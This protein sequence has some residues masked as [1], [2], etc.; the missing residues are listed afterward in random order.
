MEWMIK[1]PEGYQKIMTE[2]NV[3]PLLAKVLCFGQDDREQQVP[4]HR[5]EC[6]KDYDKVL[7]RIEKAIAGKEKV[8]IYGDYDCDGITATSIMVRAFELRGLAVGFHIPDRFTDGYGL[9]VRR[10]EEMAKKGYSLIITVDNGVSAFEAVKRANELGLDVIITDHHDLPDVLPEAYAIIHTQLSENYPFKGISGG[11]V[12]CKLATAMLKRQDPYI[13]CLAAL[14]TISDMMPMVDEN[15][16][17]VKKALEVMNTQHYLSLDLLLGENQKYDVT[18]LGFVIAPKINSIG[19]LEDGMN[20]NKCVTYFRHSGAGSDKE[21]EFKIQFA[22]S[23]LR[24]NQSR[25]RLTTSQYDVAVKNMQ[26]IGGALVA[27]EEDF[28]EGLVGLVAGKI[29]NAYYRPSFVIRKDDVSEIYKGSARSIVG[30]DMHDVLSHLQDHLL[31]FGGHEKAGGFSLSKSQWSGFC[32][33][34]AAYMHEHLTAD[35]LVERKEAI[36]IDAEDVYLPYLK[37]MACL[38]PFGQENEEPVFYM[39]ASHPSKIE[40]LSNGKH[41]KLYFD[42]P[43]ARFSALWFNHGSVYEQLSG[44]EEFELFGQLS[45]NKFRNIENVQMILKEIR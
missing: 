34:L 27:C 17:L 4:L 39:K 9:N 24:M 5:F 41:L 31:V 26:E 35:L 44:Q 11:F 30:V 16:T 12:A 25:Q 36:R 29:M 2:R 43:K 8:V 37:E 32:Q 21:R 40:T 1:E 19:R 22:S 15:R 38:E 18:S 14:S 23:A 7:V 10:V 6:F 42:L 28:H 13:F 45:V 33:G 20:P 3:G